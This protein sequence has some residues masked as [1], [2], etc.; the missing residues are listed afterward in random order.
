MSA[1]P[2]R[3]YHLQ[4]TPGEV[5]GYVLLPGDPG[6]V[7]P[8]ASLLDEA[9]PV[10]RNREFTTWSGTL[11]GVLVSVVSTGIGGPSAAIAVEELCNLDAH[12]LLRVGTCGG[13]QPGL[14]RGDLI[15]VQAAVRDEGTSHQYMPAEW[16]AAATAEVVEA[17]RA[18][19]Q[20]RAVR[21]H[22]GTVQTKDSFY[23]EME[24][25]RMPVAES[26]KARWRAL[27]AAG[28]LAS[29]MEC[30]AVLT[31]AAV[32]GARAGAVLA[33]INTTPAATMPAPQQLPLEGL[34][35]VAVGG[36]GRLVRADQTLGRT[37][38]RPQGG[39]ARG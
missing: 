30:A 5:G 39:G 2:V 38:A 36:L 37:R 16:P 3:Q 20:E 10:A 18:E 21:H 14:E 6:R 13:M 32:R 19:A 33:V 15:V 17:L 9:W 4:C 8:I 7:E 11:G 23:G 12:T 25:D 34:L 24:P 22:L 28:V 35:E 27:L 1:G 31:V 29:E 26:L